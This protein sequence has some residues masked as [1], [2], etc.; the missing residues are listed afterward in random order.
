MS[1]TLSG[2]FLVGALLIIDRPRKRKR[3]N[4]GNP[5]TIPE[6]IG[7][8]QAS[9]GQFRQSLGIFRQF[10]VFLGDLG[11]Q[12]PS[13]AF[14]SSTK[15]AEDCTPSAAV[16]G[17]AVRGACEKAKPTERAQGSKKARF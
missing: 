13:F 11:V 2:L 5:R 7:K 10:L 1:R 15:K 9:L 6:Q 8:I 3:T 17:R 16:Q 14:L 4:R 12:N